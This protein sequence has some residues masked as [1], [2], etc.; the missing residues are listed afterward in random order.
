MLHPPAF[1]VNT[2]IISLSFEDTYLAYHAFISRH[3]R[4]DRQTFMQQH[5]QAFPA[6]HL[7][8]KG[9]AT[10]LEKILPD[11]TAEQLILFRK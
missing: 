11:L 5:P 9:H 2:F 7:L 4:F 8:A 6:L 1:F 3:Q 10:N